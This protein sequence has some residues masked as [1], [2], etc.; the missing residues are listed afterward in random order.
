MRHFLSARLWTAFAILGAAA[1]VV[2]GLFAITSGGSSTSTA[3]PTTHNVELV[4]V[5]TSLAAQEGWQIANNKTVGNATLTLDDGRVVE[6]LEGT[7]GEITCINLTAPSACVLLADMLGGG[8]VWF[9]LVPVDENAASS[10]KMLTLPPLVDMLNGGSLGVLQN[11]WIV[12]L[13]DGVKR[14]CDSESD[15]ANLRE[16]I[17]KFAQN[18]VAILDLIKDEVTE[19]VCTSN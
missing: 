2:L 15:T 12:K 18:S 19:V 7:L 6:I 11:D 8:V 17:T 3:L 16:F 9:A 10:Q 1:V 14:T 4:A 5:A 13:G